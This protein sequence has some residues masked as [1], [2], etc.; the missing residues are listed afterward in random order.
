MET[1]VK[2]ENHLGEDPTQQKRASET[3]RAGRR[4]GTS[5]CGGEYRIHTMHKSTP[6]P[7][8]NE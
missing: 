1:G 3:E 5:K 2:N 4:A 7:R 6:S 8:I